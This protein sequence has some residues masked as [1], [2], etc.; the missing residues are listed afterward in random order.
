MP[1]HVHLLLSE[2]GK[3]TPV[4]V[5][6]SAEATRLAR[7]AATEEAKDQRAIVTRF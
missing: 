5:A 6:A 4:E 3:G 7:T 1:E 2:P